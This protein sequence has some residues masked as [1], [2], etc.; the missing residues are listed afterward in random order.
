[1]V[2]YTRKKAITKLQTEYIPE[3]ITIQL[4]RTDKKLKVGIM[5]L[6]GLVVEFLLTDSLDF[7]NKLIIIDLTVTRIEYSLFE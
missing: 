4:L 3:D 1:M 6:A 7:I 2:G 5:C